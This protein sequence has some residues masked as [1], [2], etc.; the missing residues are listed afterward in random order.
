MALAAGS[1]L[2]GLFKKPLYDAINWDLGK[3]PLYLEAS[4]AITSLGNILVMY[5]GKTEL[6]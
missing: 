6:N 5:P 4:N 3:D 1:P 2:T